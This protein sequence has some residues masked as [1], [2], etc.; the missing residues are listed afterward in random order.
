MAEKILKSTGNWQDDKQLLLET[1]GSG[2][3]P[4]RTIANIIH[5][6]VTYVYWLAKNNRLGTCVGHSYNFLLPQLIDYVEN[7]SVRRQA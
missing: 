4:S 1:Y 3:I 6:P 2:C 7:A 5:K